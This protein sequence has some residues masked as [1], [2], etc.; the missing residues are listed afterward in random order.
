MLAVTHAA[1]GLLAGS[2]CASLAGLPSAAGGLLG[3]AGALLPDIDHPGS[4]IGRRVPFVSWPL[5]LAFG[6]RGV[7]HSLLAVLACLAALPLA[8]VAPAALPVAL[9]YL[10]HLLAD[11]CTPAGVPFLWPSPRVFR[12]P[13]VLRT[14][15]LPELALAG[16]LWLV[17][18]FSILGRL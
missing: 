1:L 7:T 12:S 4:W 14:G 11:Y 5:A 16:L 3:V 8:G 2:A 10:S 13:Y 17:A 18:M 6:H 15:S 9:G